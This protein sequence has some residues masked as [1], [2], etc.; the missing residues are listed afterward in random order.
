M[1]QNEREK[2][3]ATK[4]KNISFD[5]GSIYETSNQYDTL[6]GHDIIYEGT[7]NVHGGSTFGTTL[8]ET[9][10]LFYLSASETGSWYKNKG[11]DSTTSVTFGYHLEDRENS[12]YHNEN[13]EEYHELK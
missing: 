12:D 8:N 11:K 3:E 4:E 2:I 13:G 1:Q 7:A 5:A 9:G 6:K 10:V